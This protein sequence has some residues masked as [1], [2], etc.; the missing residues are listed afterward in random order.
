MRPGNVY[1]NGGSPNYTIFDSHC[2]SLVRFNV[3]W[4]V[5]VD[6]TRRSVEFMQTL[7]NEASTHSAQLERYA[8]GIELVSGRKVMALLADM[9]GSVNVSLRRCMRFISI[10]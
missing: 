9:G 7:R 5:V 4:S 8:Q 2:G 3:H 10:R 1:W 6:S